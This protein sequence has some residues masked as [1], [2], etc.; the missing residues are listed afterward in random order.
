MAAWDR[1]TDPAGRPQAAVAV[2]NVRT[3]YYL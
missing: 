1:A 2:G 3:S